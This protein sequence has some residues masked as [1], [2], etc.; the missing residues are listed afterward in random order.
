[1]S[2]SSVYRIAFLHLTSCGRLRLSESRHGGHRDHTGG[3]G[4]R[5]VNGR[6]LIVQFSRTHPRTEPAP[7]LTVQAHNNNRPAKL[8]AKESSCSTDNR[9]GGEQ[10]VEPS[11]H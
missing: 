4:V 9:T 3:D 5:G 6:R 2:T 7:G 11:V 1:M 10:Q 8:P